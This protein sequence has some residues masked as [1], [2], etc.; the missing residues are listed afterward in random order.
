MEYLR[1]KLELATR[2]Q[3]AKF[4][5]SSILLITIYNRDHYNDCGLD[6]SWIARNEAMHRLLGN[7][8]AVLDNQ[9][10]RD[11]WFDAIIENLKVIPEAALIRPA[12]FLE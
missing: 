1:S 2:D 8:G 9:S 5:V 6:P 4:I 7:L 11:I 10:E 3:L 12:K